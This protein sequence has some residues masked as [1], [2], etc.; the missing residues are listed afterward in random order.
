MAG[1]AAGKGTPGAFEVTHLREAQVEGKEHA[2]TEQQPGEIPGSTQQ[3][4]KEC[5]EFVQSNHDILRYI[6]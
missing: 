4:V 6:I 2:H 3:T 5:Q 1:I